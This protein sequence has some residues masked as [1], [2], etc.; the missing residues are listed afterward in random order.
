[1]PAWQIPVRQINSLQSFP[2]WETTSWPSTDL[3]FNSEHNEKVCRSAERRNTF[4]YNH[5]PHLNTTDISAERPWFLFYNSVLW[6]NHLRVLPW[7]VYNFCS[8]GRPYDKW[9]GDIKILYLYVKLQY[10]QPEVNSGKY[11]TNMLIKST[12]IFY[13]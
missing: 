2:Y 1:M 3:G 11:K 9:K 8:G 7:K 12:Y 4:Y 10:N 5:W 6:V 13:M